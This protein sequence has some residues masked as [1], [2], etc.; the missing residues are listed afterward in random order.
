MTLMKSY[1]THT[2]WESE[3]HTARLRVLDETFKT[4]ETRDLNRRRPASEMLLQG[5]NSTYEC[6][7][8]SERIERIAYN[9]LNNSNVNPLRWVWDAFTVSSSL[10]LFCCTAVADFDQKWQKSQNCLGWPWARGLGLARTTSSLGPAA[11]LFFKPTTIS[12][13]AVFF[14]SARHLWVNVSE[15]HHWISGSPVSKQHIQVLLSCSPSSS[16]VA[17]R[18]SH[19]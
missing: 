5:L 10:A 19:R 7:P 14:V 6:K 16:Q 17:N 3:F 2:P 9:S 13:N 12:W 8:H 15:N 11:W 1:H 4:D 18:I